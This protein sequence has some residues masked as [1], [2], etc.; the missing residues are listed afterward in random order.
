MADDAIS[1]ASAPI[2]I[3]GEH[4]SGTTLLAAILGAH[5]QIILGLELNFTEPPDLGP[6]L[7]AYCALVRDGGGAVPAKGTPQ[8]A[9]FWA[10]QLF[11]RQCEALGVARDVVESLTRRVMGDRRSDLKGFRDR[12]AL[13]D[14]IGQWRTEELGVCHWGFKIQRDII[15]ARS[16]AEY[17]PAARFVHIVR[18]GRDV[19][20]SH[21]RDHSDWGCRDAAA[22]A[23]AWSDV[24]AATRPLLGW[25]QFHEVKYENLVREP[26]ATLSRLMEFLGQ[27]WEEVL[28]SHAR[29]RRSFLNLETYRHPSLEAAREPINGRALSRYR[30]DLTAEEVQA[31]ERIAGP[32]LTALGYT[33]S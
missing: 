19:A 25:A 24:V 13:V 31:V 16:L 2:F 1:S 18:D 4:R 8:A 3:G 20:A 12:C 7:L 22:A 9:F 32:W 23:A 14:A 33:G 30:K 26:R 15:T 11:L 10:I 6:H 5:S 28:L 21:V 29:E 27:P 17:W